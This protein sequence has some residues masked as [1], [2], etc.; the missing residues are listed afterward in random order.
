[1]LMMT[2]MTAASQMVVWT[3]QAWGAQIRVAQVFYDAALQQSRLLWDLPMARP[4][5]LCGVA[6]VARSAAKPAARAAEMEA[7]LKALQ[8]RYAHVADVRGRGLLWGFEFVMDRQGND[9]AEGVLLHGVDP[10]QVRQRV[11]GLHAARPRAGE[12]LGDRTDRVP[13][14]CGRGLRNREAD[15]A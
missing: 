8:Q 6:P 3:S 4:V 9:L 13:E 1:M 12:E 5:S 10:E 15:R 2:P 7:G 14:L 11:E